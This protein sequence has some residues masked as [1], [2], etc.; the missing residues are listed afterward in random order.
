MLYNATQCE[1]WSERGRRRR[2]AVSRYPSD[3]GRQHC[4]SG[5][6]AT[7]RVA[8]LGRQSSERRSDGCTARLFFMRKGAR[9]R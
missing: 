9:D 5:G 1:S 6:V 7:I 8:N 3:I 4:S 2:G